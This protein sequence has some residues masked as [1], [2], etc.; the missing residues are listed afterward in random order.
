MFLLFSH[1]KQTLM[2]SIAEHE[3]EEDLNVYEPCENLQPKDT[4][5]HTAQ[6]HSVYCS[7]SIVNNIL[8]QNSVCMPELFLVR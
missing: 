3:K 7:Y 6:L 1:Q 8:Y 2:A 4:P 5:S